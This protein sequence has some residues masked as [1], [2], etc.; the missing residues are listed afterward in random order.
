MKNVYYKDIIKHDFNI[1]EYLK[2]LISEV[3]DE[4]FGKPKENQKYEEESEVISEI[5][6]QIVDKV[7]I[8]IKYNY[9]DIGIKAGD[10]LY[11]YF[12]HDSSIVEEHQNDP[13][14]T[15]IVLDPIKKYVKIMGNEYS[16]VN[17]F[18]VENNLLKSKNTINAP[19][20]LYTEA[21]HFS[22]QREL[23]NNK[24]DISNRKEVRDILKHYESIS[25]KGYNWCLANYKAA[26]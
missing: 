3:I 1:T 2:E 19:W 14:M 20:S 18:L 24:V 11:F 17:K 25:R 9:A 4:K 7:K 15:V 13:P 22:I 5:E 26:E 8:P 23:V 10:V 6:E 21:D 16:T 12:Q